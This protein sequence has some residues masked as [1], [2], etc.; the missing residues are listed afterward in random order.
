M[1]EVKVNMNKMTDALS[2]VVDE[3]RSMDQRFENLIRRINENI[4]VRDQKTEAKIAGIEKH[5]DAEIEEKFTD[6]G[7]RK[8]AVEKTDQKQTQGPAAEKVRKK[9]HELFRLNAKR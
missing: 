7:R 1:T 6:L 3:S 5:I 9:I 2:N 8:Y 4:R